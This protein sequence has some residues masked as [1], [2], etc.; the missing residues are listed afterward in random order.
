M[1]RPLDKLIIDESAV[2]EEIMTETLMPYMQVIRETGGIVFTDAY[3]DLKPKEKILVYFLGKRA[4]NALELGDISASPKTVERETGIVGNTAR[5]T[6]RELLGERLLAQ[7]G[8][9]YYLPTHALNKICR[10]IG[11]KDDER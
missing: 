1:D 4:I 9:E 7:D 3:D 10:R 6:L 11:G 5:R 8:K 2:N